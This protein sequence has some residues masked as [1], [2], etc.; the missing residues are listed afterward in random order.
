[1]TDVEAIQHLTDV[2]Q[3]QTYVEGA[4]WIAWFCAMVLIG[5]VQVAIWPELRSRRP[6]KH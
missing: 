1:M 2:V 3:E 5:G 4:G 6:T